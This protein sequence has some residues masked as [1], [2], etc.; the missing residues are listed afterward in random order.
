MA[1]SSCSGTRLEN[2]GSRL[3]GR[4]VVRKEGEMVVKEHCYDHKRLQ[5]HSKVLWDHPPAF[6]YNFRF[7]EL[8][9]ARSTNMVEKKCWKRGATVK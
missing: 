4:G 9:S 8:I 3:A 2:S 5:R 7:F 6:F 1:Q